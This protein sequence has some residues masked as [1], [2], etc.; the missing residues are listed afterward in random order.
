MTIRTVIVDDEPWARTR[1]ATLLNSEPD[2]EI[3]RACENGDEAI[4]A[5]TTL[6]PN[7]VFLD[8][9]MPV[10]DGFAV[11]DAIA[12]EAMPLVVFATAYE[13]YALKA[14]DTQALD[15]LLKPFD[16]E[17]FHRCLQ[18]VRREVQSP[19]PATSAL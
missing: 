19:R 15:Y 5:I 4:E 14:F 12:V 6:T 17:R 2:F 1:I 18:R 3:V 8:V 11:V 9:Q 7:V 13:R 10:V 16:E